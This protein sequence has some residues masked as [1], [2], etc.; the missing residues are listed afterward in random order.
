MAYKASFTAVAMA[1]IL[2]YHNK[3]NVSASNRPLAFSNANLGT[4]TGTWASS[5]P[6]GTIRTL[7]T[8]DNTSSAAAR[9][10][11]AALMYQVGQTALAPYHD[12]DFTFNITNVVNAF[13]ALGYNIS[14]SGDLAYTSSYFS[15][16]APYGNPSKGYNITYYITPASI[17]NQLNQNRPIYTHG[18]NQYY[19]SGN[20]EW[21]IEWVMDGH[22]SI[23]SYL[24]I[25]NIGYNIGN[26]PIVTRTVNFT[27]CLMVHCNFGRDGFAN[28][29]YVYGVFD[30]V[31]RY[32]ITGYDGTAGNGVYKANTQLVVPY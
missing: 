26:S 1:Q 3:I 32:H 29:W 24:E 28:G 22:G 17:I 5:N 18:Q 4:W 10:Q 19:D 12:S 23:T 27:D 2:A 15:T 14:L 11:I 25:I 6:F 20:E 9:G 7:S 30:T 8:I 31:D 16:G 21:Q 13:I